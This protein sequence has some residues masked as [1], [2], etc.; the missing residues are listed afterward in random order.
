[1]PEDLTQGGFVQA[2]A[3]KDLGIFS[4]IAQRC[5]LIN[6]NFCAGNCSIALCILLLFIRA[7]AHSMRNNSCLFIIKKI[8][9][10]CSVAVW[11][12]YMHY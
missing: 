7:P 3:R 4:E 12:C 1:M 5:I 11:R 6:I 10:Q 8:C 2:R 9:L